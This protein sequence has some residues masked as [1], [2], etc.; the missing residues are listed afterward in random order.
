M[1]FI[2]V[3]AGVA[4]LPQIIELWRGK[5]NIKKDLP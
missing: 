1:A 4:T 3:M 5:D 2:L